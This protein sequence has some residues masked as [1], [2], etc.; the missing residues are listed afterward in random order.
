M[1]EELLNEKIEDF[2]DR[3]TF[4]EMVEVWRTLFPE[5]NSDEEFMELL[6]VC[7]NSNLDKLKLE[8]ENE[9]CF[10]YF[11]KYTSK[12]IDKEVNIILE[13]I[14]DE[15]KLKLKWINFYSPI[16]NYYSEDLYNFL[17]DRHKLAD[18]NGLMKDIITYMISNLHT[19]AFKV[20][21]YDT[22]EARLNNL[23]KG[24][25][26]EERANF[27]SEVL[28]KDES[29]LNSLYKEYNEL[30]RLMDISVS[31]SVDYIKSIILN[32][33]NNFD[34]IVKSLDVEKDDSIVTISL[35]EG[36]THNGGKTVSILKFK[37]GKKLVYKPRVL[38]IDIK[39]YNFIEWINNQEIGEFLKLKAPK[40]Y[41]IEEVGW[42]EFIED[43]GCNSLD[44]VK[45]YYKRSGQLLSLMYS[46]NSKDFHMENVIA[47]G[48]QP[49]L[50]D[51]ETLLHSNL[52]NI[53]QEE[54]SDTQ[55]AINIIKE[56]VN[57]IGFLPMQIINEKSG[58]SIDVG[59][60]TASET[61]ESAIKSSFISNYDKDDVKVER[62]YSI[63]NPS[64]N[65][66]KIKEEVIKS[67]EFINDIIQGFR[68]TYM[69]ILENKEKFKFKVS[70]LF[71]NTSCRVL[72]RSTSVYA[73]VLS[74]SYHPDLLRSTLDRRV[75]LHRIAVKSTKSLKKQVIES[76][77]LD[78][79]QGDIPYFYADTNNLEI[80]TC[81]NKKIE[82]VF[83][84]PI[85]ET[86]LKKI[87]KFSIDDMERQIAIIN[88]S[89]LNKIDGF[90]DETNIKFK[91]EGS[92]NIDKN[93]CLKLACEIG[94]YIIRKS[95]CGKGS[96]AK[97]RT[98][99]G[100][101]EVN[102]LFL[103]STVSNNLYDGNSGIAL[104]L[105]ALGKVSDNEA[106]TITAKDALIDVKEYL[107][108]IQKNPINQNDKDDGDKKIGGFSGISGM[109]Y[110]IYNIGK[111]TADKELVDY[112]KDKISIINSMI[113]DTKDF[114]VI[115][116]LT[117]AL[118]VLLSIYDKEKSEEFKSY[119][120]GICNKIFNKLKDLAVS[121]EGIEGI[122]FDEEG[123][124][125]FS[126]GNAGVSAF[127]MKLYSVTENDKILDMIKQ[128]LDYERSMYDKEIKNWFRN[129]EQ[130]YPS[131]N[132][133]NGAPGIL[134]SKA[135]L[136]KYGYSDEIIED[137]IKTAIE[138]TKNHGFGTDYCMC[139]GDVGHLRVLK[140]VSE[141][142]G[143]KDFDKKYF[144]N[145]ENFVDEF[146]KPYLSEDRHKY[147]ESYGIMTGISGIGYGLLQ[148]LS[149]DLPEIL[150]LDSI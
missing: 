47:Q 139:H 41:F 71:G 131:C 122:I 8:Y 83:N 9:K 145:I 116:G 95:I 30:I 74:T 55:V 48:E 91:D 26:P 28:L 101:V 81:R 88:T 24:N 132:W 104:F 23:L 100:T 49:I 15:I 70:E 126:H 68:K 38:D 60:L 92:N 63:I 13:T 51:L 16:L 115:V 46:L 39:Y 42:V 17:N 79:F 77:Y 144:D 96:K 40:V 109:I 1:R 12:V 5:V 93:K 117:G 114:D 86:I 58:K 36:D 128:L 103:V 65:N 120:I 50:I 142:L 135:M 57:V 72:F 22:N 108:Y 97:N 99:L 25:S 98:W 87:S 32:T 121:K 43:C 19:I 69:W 67:Q 11:G 112:A 118:G 148:A 59:G 35:S 137:E 37:S 21:V 147:K 3:Y 130:R 62:R 110:S 33:E 85:I 125:G 64:K 106:Y 73:Q 78:L 2:D 14:L 140:I 4:E 75:Y 136:L 149:D 133:C 127:L 61:Q 66:P 27:Y 111:I 107:D 89:Y 76:E 80:S 134:L 143:H 124:V 129:L 138:L 53:E 113:D 123:Y 94:D 10:D 56:S 18:K 119:L 54:L 105:A 29:Y 146:L 90:K 150:I 31:N 44:E 20:M 82:G 7:T 141:I 34:K 6:H 52:Y 102:K 45:N 84:E